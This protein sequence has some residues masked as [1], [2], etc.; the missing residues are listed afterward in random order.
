MAFSIDHA[1]QTGLA[2]QGRDY[3][4]LSIFSRSN[5]K[6]QIAKRIGMDVTFIHIFPDE[7]TNLILHIL[8]E[9]G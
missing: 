3:G 1:R 5:Q 7:V 6:A 4:C 2:R 9:V 8:F